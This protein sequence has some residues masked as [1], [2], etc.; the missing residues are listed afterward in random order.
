MGN[1][2]AFSNI[3]AREMLIRPAWHPEPLHAPVFFHGA[4][5]LADV[6]PGVRMA[7]PDQAR[8]TKRP[9]IT[10]KSESEPFYSL[11]LRMPS[12][13]PAAST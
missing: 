2:L 9:A 5:G 11:A 1:G 12:R 4:A 3:R 8:T 7:R 10:V 6:A 13:S